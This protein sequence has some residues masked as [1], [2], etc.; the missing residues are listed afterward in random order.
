MNA[1]IRN[2]LLSVVAGGCV[3][4][5]ASGWEGK[6][7][8]IAMEGQEI[9]TAER[10]I[11]PREEEGPAQESAAPLSSL[12]SAG[13]Q[14]RPARDFGSN[15]LPLDAE[16][17]ELRSYWMRSADAGAPR[18]AIDRLE[19]FAR[20]HADD[21]RLAGAALDIREDLLG[22]RARK[23]DWLMPREESGAV[24]NPETGEGTPPERGE[25]WVPPD[26]IDLDR[27][28]TISETIRYG[29]DDRVILAGVQELAFYRED[30]VSQTLLEVAD[31]P[32]VDIRKT[33]T[34]ALW[35]SAAEGIEVE[36]T[37]DRLYYL[38]R[39]SNERVSRLAERAL[40][41]LARLEERANR[42]V[43]DSGLNDSFSI[44]EGPEG[45]ED[46]GDDF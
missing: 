3:W 25:D 44:G 29:S 27:Y 22:V 41:D 33:A 10:V 14:V 19:A 28:E 38:A 36:A 1:W 37:R 34:E 32:S 20:A 16:L 8:P 18:Q 45:P 2:S 31:H 7:T 23:N 30:M 40:A 21:E 6:E 5:I 42:P 13:Q 9:V 26:W 11:T 43:A 35:R 4:G 15:G 17:S 24:W 39:D 46:R 12:P